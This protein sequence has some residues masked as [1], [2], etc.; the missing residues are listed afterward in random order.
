[1]LYG[2]SKYKKKLFLVVS[3][4]SARVA[5]GCECGCISLE[6]DCTV[7]K[8]SLDPLVLSVSDR[9]EK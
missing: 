2:V 8:L 6:R 7:S 4:V 3:R 1:M 9:I 5:R